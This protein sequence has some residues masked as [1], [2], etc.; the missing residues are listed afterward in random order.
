MTSADSPSE[1]AESRVEP[2]R[3]LAVGVVGLGYVGLPLAIAFAASGARV[4]AVDN[5]PD[6]VAQLLR[7]ESYIEDVPSG[8]LATMRDHMTLTTDYEALRRVDAIIICVPTPLTINREPDLRALRRA[9][10]G[11]AEVLRAGQLVVLESTSY[12]GTTR[13]ELVP[14]L[15]MSGLRA[16]RDFHVAFSPERVDPGR[17]DFTLRTTPKVVGG[18][19]DASG[20]RACAVYAGICDSIVRV[21]SPEAAE[22]DQTSRE[23]LP[24]GQHRARERALHLVR[25]YGH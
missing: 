5:D 18:L 25:P 17:T 12:P 3:L 9:A 19:N 10:T 22:I 21:A 4:V 7:G 6:R 8:A 16:G 15:E 11:V 1:T 23:Y 24:L 13:D 2:Q 20:S 14:A